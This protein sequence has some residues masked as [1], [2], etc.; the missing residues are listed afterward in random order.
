[1][2]AMVSL[3]LMWPSIVMRLKED[4]TAFL[5][6]SLRSRVDME[7]SVVRK[8]SMVA[9]FGA[10][11]PAPLVIP[12]T[13]T[14]LLFIFNLTAMSFCFVSVVIMARAT[15]LPFVWG[16]FFARAG[17]AARAFGWWLGGVPRGGG[18]GFN[19]RRGYTPPGGPGETPPQHM[20]IT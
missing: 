18:R 17:C 2:I 19:R 16:G 20:A 10:I 8:H 6:H 15:L 14:S 5:R 3:V 9:R 4:S 7:T 13:I 11:I 12:P 1:M